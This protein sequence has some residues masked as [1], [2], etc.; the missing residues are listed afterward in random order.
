MLCSVDHHEGVFTAR[1]LV[2]DTVRILFTRYDLGFIHMDMALLHILKE[3]L[4]VRSF[5]LD[6]KGICLYAVPCAHTCR[7]GYES[8]AH[9]PPV[10]HGYLV[11]YL[12]PC[13]RVE[14]LVDTRPAHEHHIWFFSFH[15]ISPL[16]SDKKFVSLFC[17]SFNIH[18]VDFTEEQQILRRE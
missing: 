13:L 6:V 3:H 15:H 9:I 2:Y 8:A 11:S 14:I 1:Q 16:I 5:S 4:R 17:N 18:S 7:I 12:R 10:P